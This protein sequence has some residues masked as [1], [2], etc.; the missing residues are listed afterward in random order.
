MADSDHLQKIAYPIEAEVCSWDRDRRFHLKDADVIEVFEV[1]LDLY[2][3]GDSPETVS[4]RVNRLGCQRVIQGLGHQ[5]RRY[6]RNEIVKVIGVVRFTAKR[7]TLGG[8]EHIDLLHHYC[9]AFV[10]S[11]VSRRSFSEFP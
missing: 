2:G 9:G 3:F 4:D 11:D 7:R 8:R 6:D 5:L 1:L 10:Q